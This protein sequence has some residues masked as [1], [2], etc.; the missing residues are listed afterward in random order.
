M[1]VTDSVA[2]SRIGQIEP[3]YYK[4]SLILSTGVNYSV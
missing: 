1:A 3:D 4:A 2:I